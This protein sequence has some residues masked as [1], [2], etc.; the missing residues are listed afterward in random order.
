MEQR[1][2]NDADCAMP[3]FSVRT[4]K[5]IA[6]QQPPATL[7]DDDAESVVSSVTTASVSSS[8]Q[9]TKMT[10][11]AGKLRKDRYQR[12]SQ[13][14]KQAAAKK[15]AVANSVHV[16]EPSAEERDQQHEETSI[17][18][19]SEDA[20]ATRDDDTGEPNSAAPDE[21]ILDDVIDSLFEAEESARQIRR[22]SSTGEKVV[23]IEEEILITTSN[24]CNEANCISPMSKT[25][26]YEGNEDVDS[27]ASICFPEDE[28][29]VDD[30]GGIMEG[31]DEDEAKDGRRCSTP[32]LSSNK[33]CVVEDFT[34]LM[35]P[36]PLAHNAELSG[37]P[38]LV[39]RTIIPGRHTKYEPV[40]PE[41]DPNNTFTGLP[42]SSST[43]A[44]LS[45]PTL[46]ESPLEGELQDD[47]SPDRQFKSYT[48]SLTHDENKIL[49]RV[50]SE[51]DSGSV[52]SI[53]SHDND[54]PRDFGNDCIASMPDAISLGITRHSLDNEEEDEDD[55]DDDYDYSE[56]YSIISP[57]SLGF[58]ERWSS[59]P[60]DWKERHTCLLRY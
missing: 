18:A 11:K 14:K 33:E 22:L 19:E 55:E 5:Q 44:F 37:P 8:T 23:K 16:D 7:S 1:Q 49:K 31:R 60:I 6:I 29:E 45:L 17:T 47:M 38:A 24:E 58:L 2:A 53:G 41:T 51:N 34:R 32:I 35:P 25:C 28:E 52:V 40:T 3:S 4:T 21:S 26:P 15:T 12:R 46:E 59:K 50:L 36:T 57:P 42:L 56:C 9:Y 43:R 10:H 13:N 48:E 54:G 39:S 20:E 30:F 27:F